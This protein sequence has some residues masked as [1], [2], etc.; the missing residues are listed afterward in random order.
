MGDRRSV[1]GRS[2]RT[3]LGLAAVAATLATAAPAS[4]AELL[5]ESVSVDRPVLR[6]CVDR[7]GGDGAVQRSVTAPAS[8]WLTARLRAAEGDW[9]VAV[10]DEQSGDQLGG[11]AS[12]GSEE[13]AEV[14]VVDGQQL[15]VQACRLSGEAA[16]AQLDVESVAV[17]PPAGDFRPSVVAVSTP[18]KGRKDQLLGLGLD[19]TEHGGPGFIAVVLR[20]VQDAQVLRKN[21]FVYK[22]LVADLVGQTI[23][24]RAAERRW[25]RSVRASNLPSGRETYRTLADYETEMKTLAQENPTLV[26][27][28]ELPFKT[29]TGRTVQGIEIT[30]DVNAR[31]GKP[32][33]LQM[34]AH[35]AREWPSAEHAME[36]AY[37]LINGYKAGNARV[38]GL[39]HSTRTIVIPVINPDGFN[40]SRSAGGA[41][42]NGREGVETANLAIP[43][44]YHRK[45]CRTTNPSGDDPESGNC[46]QQPATGIS[47]F[48]TDPNRNYGGFWGGPGASAAGGEPPG[49]YNQDYRG[50]GPFSEPETQNVRDLVSKRH[51]T[52][53]ITNHT[54]SNLVLRPPGLQS[55]GLTPDENRGYKALGDAMAAENGYTSQYSWQLYDTSGTTE[56]WTYFATG[57]YGFTFEIGCEDKDEESQEC[58]DFHFHP[59]YQKVVAEYEGTTVEADENG[60]D[61]LGNREAYF[62]AQQNTADAAQ[63]S[64]L[65]GR[66]PGGAVLRLAKSFDTAT[67]RVLD[68]E[69]REGERQFFRDNL[70][71]SMEVPGSSSFEWHVNPST[72]PLHMEQIGRPSTGPASDPIQ[73]SGNLVLPDGAAACGNFD[74]ENEACWNDHAFEVPNDPSRDNGRFT[75]RI[76]WH[77]PG[78]DWDMKVFVDSDGDGSSVGETE[79]V[80]SSAQFATSWEQASVSEPVVAPGK[81]FVARVINFA[82]A[83]PYEGE[84][85]FHQ[86]EFFDKRTESWR[87]TCESHSG[88]VLTSQDVT[89][90][91]GERQDPG[92]QRCI[93]AFQRAFASGRGC[94]R[95]TGRVFRKGLDRARLGRDRNDHLRRY[96]IGLKGRRN[97]DKFCLSDRRV[98]RIGYP[99][100]RVLRQNLGRSRGGFAPSKAVLVLTSSRRF[101]VRRVRVGMRPAI[102]R[103]RIGR[104]IRPIRIGANR[105]YLRR[106]RG[107][108]LVFKVRAGRVREV[109]HAPL[110]L[111]NTRRKSARL[112]RSFPLR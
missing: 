65:G 102:M 87:L 57:G 15:T 37:E 63:H 36:W 79:M 67:S 38:R 19:V 74:T 18:N 29:W 94:D 100:D 78:S 7:P 88:T 66:A 30:T 16:R 70:D 68:P 59:S 107:A 41:S 40:A 85:S 76:D 80:G 10:F 26:K 98:V 105:W 12:P 28:I 95:P 104:R 103:R 99:T 21:G 33:F 1:A 2:R 108:R 91:R 72:R 75:V 42:A 24:D 35:H 20:S 8:G 11:G 44:E 3:A 48:G 13:L 58:L 82:A 83:D 43:Y 45:N 92:L 93:T 22:T 109:G 14:F 23:A 71:T 62:K 60:R 39:M 86:P 69:G 50:N 53:L 64:V 6:S 112:L 111:T 31:D 89:I 5:G 17:K 32:V 77:E 54:A 27:P 46:T 101:R 25:A 47:Q 34:G 51:V 52:T 49:D 55:L 84:I 9:D 4:A 110:R 81:K 90:N 73:F 96:R 97:L 56:D 106:G 61:G